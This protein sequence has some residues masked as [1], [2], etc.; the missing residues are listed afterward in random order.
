MARLSMYHV[1]YNDL[2]GQIQE[3]T[4]PSG[5]Q[6]PNE[7][8]LAQRYGVSHMTIR[9]ALDQLAR[10]GA[11][12]RRRGVRT[13]VADLASG[14][15]YLSSIRPMH[16]ELG[17]PP[18][19]V[20]TS[21]VKNYTGEPPADVADRLQLTDGASATML[22]RLRLIDDRPI[23][24]QT[25]WLPNTVAPRLAH[26][27]LIGGSLY[28]TLQERYGIHLAWAEQRIY[29]AT[30]SHKQADLLNVKER[31]PLIRTER[32]SYSD[33]NDRVEFSTSWITNNYPVIIRLENK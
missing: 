18:D 25:S 17:V 4:L 22:T 16:A 15:R 26:E 23:A 9:Q 33:A 12:I 27:P 7:A 2:I 31:S 14:G 5:A 19:A 20:T 11:I 29:A 21:I 24:I 8:E 1:I 10:E 30:A 3:G 6:L 13:I 28:R 32:L